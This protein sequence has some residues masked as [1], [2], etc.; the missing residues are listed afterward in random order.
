MNS[1]KTLQFTDDK[2]SRFQDNTKNAMDQL[3]KIPL[4]D[5]VLIEGIKLTSGQDNQVSHQLG[6]AY[7]LWFP[8]R[9]DTNSTLFEQTSADSSRFIN[10]HC[11]ATCTV[12]LWCA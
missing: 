1:M 4:I 7:R 6:R 2:I 3:H 8:V 9:Q 12:S 5:G 10:I 11:S